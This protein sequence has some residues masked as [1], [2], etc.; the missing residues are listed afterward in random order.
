M[1][2]EGHLDSRGEDMN[3]CGVT[4]LV[5]WQHKGRLRIIKFSRDRL[6]LIG[7]ET[8]CIQN[9]SQ[10]IATERSSRENIHSH[11]ASI[12]G[13]SPALRLGETSANGD[14]L[15]SIRVAHVSRVEIRLV[16]QP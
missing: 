1:P 8:L 6:H 10:R 16:V 13:I 11:V 12:H 5:W 14:Q 4:G 3:V 9:D 2:G 15:I 7:R